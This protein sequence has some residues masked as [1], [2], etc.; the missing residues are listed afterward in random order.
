MS[1]SPTFSTSPGQSATGDHAGIVEQA[2]DKIGQVADQAQHSAGQ[3]T[4]QVKQQATSQLEAQKER[5][6]DSLVTVAQA[7]RQTGQHL[8]EQKQDGVAGYVEQAAERVENLTNHMRARDVGQLLDDTE[9]LARARPGL[10][11]GAALA[12]GFV[13]ARFLM[14]SGRRARTPR[15]F[16]LSGQNSNAH[17]QPGYGYGGSTSSYGRPAGQGSRMAVPG[18][19]VYGSSYS[20]PV[21]STGGIDGAPSGTPVA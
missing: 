19:A 8:H 9:D 2:Q 15:D 4:E 1:T 11:M 7:L 17:A 20:A 10:F 12:L 6:V 14:S 3:V 18:S 21:P 13:G 5:A 16:S